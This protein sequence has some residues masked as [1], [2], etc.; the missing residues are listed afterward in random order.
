MC[1]K[2]NPLALNMLDF[3]FRSYM[4]IDHKALAGGKGTGEASKKTGDRVVQQGR[5]NLLGEEY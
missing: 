3:L 2:V 4:E 1:I 5:P